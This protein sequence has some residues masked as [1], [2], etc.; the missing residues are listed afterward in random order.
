MLASAQL[1]LD[2]LQVQRAGLTL[3]VRTY[4]IGE[5]LTDGGDG[6]I[7]PCEAAPIET[8]LVVGGFGRDLAAAEFAVE[9]LDGS[10]IFHGEFLCRQA[11]DG[12]LR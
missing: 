10:E 5:S 6:L 2:C 4:I 11:P 1:L 12:A 9:R 7:F 8:E 3:G